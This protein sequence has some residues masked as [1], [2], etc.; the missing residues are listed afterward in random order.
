MENDYHELIDVVWGKDDGLAGSMGA[1][2]KKLEN[3]RG[4]LKEWS[5]GKLAN[6]EQAIKQQTALL[7]ELQRDEDPQNRSAIRQ[8]QEKIDKMLEQEDLKWRQRAKQSWYQKG[9]WN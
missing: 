3:C 7:Q 2:Q 4:A 5:R 6:G 9:D 1:V 8:L